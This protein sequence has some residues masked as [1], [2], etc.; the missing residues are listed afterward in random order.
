[1]TLDLLGKN[2]ILILMIASKQF[3]ETVSKVVDSFFMHN[4][5]TTKRSFSLSYRGLGNANSYKYTRLE[6]W[7][8]LKNLSS[9]VPRNPRN[10]LR[11][12][13]AMI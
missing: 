9:L 4:V 6:K 13:H 1:M 10:C 11:S 5:L 8:L 3:V 12:I 7:S 2:V